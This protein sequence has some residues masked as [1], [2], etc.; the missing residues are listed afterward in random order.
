MMHL[1]LFG[2]RYLFVILVFLL[3]M[4][5]LVSVMRKLVCMSL[6]YCSIRQ[7]GW[8]FFVLSMGRR[9]S[10]WSFVVLKSG[11]ITRYPNAKTPKQ[12]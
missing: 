11:K 2:L 8:S 3:W 6:A 7:F 5:L 9:R 12:T 10:C 4:L 1:S